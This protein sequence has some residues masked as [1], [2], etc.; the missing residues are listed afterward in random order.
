MRGLPCSCRSRLLQLLTDAQRPFGHVWISSRALFIRRSASLACS[1]WDMAGGF[2]RTAGAC[3]CESASQCVA[4]SAIFARDSSRCVRA[5]SL[6]AQEARDGS[7]SANREHIGL[8]QNPRGPAD[9]GQPADMTL[10]LR[11]NPRWRPDAGGRS[12]VRAVLR[13]KSSGWAQVQINKLRILKNGRA[14]AVTGIRAP[15]TRSRS[16]VCDRDGQPFPSA[17]RR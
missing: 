17:R 4:R 14:P 5:I 12:S 8:R 3:L 6:H 15:K 16:R 11:K 1:A 9:E 2:A 10:F 13:S 7:A